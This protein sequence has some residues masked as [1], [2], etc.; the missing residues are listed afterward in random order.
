MCEGE[1]VGPVFSKSSLSPTRTDE[2]PAEFLGMYFFRG[3]LDSCY[4]DITDNMGF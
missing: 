3:I 1:R 2:T 4:T